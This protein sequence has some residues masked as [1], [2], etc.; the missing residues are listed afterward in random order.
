[1]VPHIP[2]FAL[3]VRVFT[4]A[5]PQSVRFAIHPQADSR[6]IWSLG[7]TMPQAPQFIS[8][9][10]VSTHIMLHIMPTGHVHAES[11]QT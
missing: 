7:H 5:P 6:Q 2:Q 3:S 4:H 11:R 1:M 10:L 9:I 8:S